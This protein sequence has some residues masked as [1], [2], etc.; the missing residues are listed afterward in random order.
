MLDILVY[1]FRKK[2][3]CQALTSD[4]RAKRYPEICHIQPSHLFS[5]YG[6]NGRSLISQALFHII[7]K[8]LCRSP[9]QSS[10]T[11]T[12]SLPQSVSSFP[13]LQHKAFK[14]LWNS[15]QMFPMSFHYPKALLALYLYLPQMLEKADRITDITTL[16]LNRV[17]SETYSEADI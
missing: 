3:L 9:W 16:D 11:F 15:F 5:G 7:Q 14:H 4:G 2:R 12:V 8:N 1:M 17:H 13:W 6:D 10:N